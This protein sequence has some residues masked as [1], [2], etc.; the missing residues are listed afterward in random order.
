MK[1]KGGGVVRRAIERERENEGKREQGEGESRLIYH[2]IH[3]ESPTK[4]K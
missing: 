4:R 2:S 3:L 1:E